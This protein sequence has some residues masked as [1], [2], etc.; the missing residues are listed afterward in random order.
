MIS[1]CRT[2]PL[3]LTLLCQGLLLV[4]TP[5]TAKE[6][7]YPDPQQ[8]AKQPTFENWK[9]SGKHGAVAA[10]GQRAVDA[11]IAMLKSDGNAID[12]AVATLLALTVTDSNSYCFGGE[13]PI[14]VYDAK[15]GVV[16]CLCGLGTA[17]KLA[18]REFFAKMGG[19]PTRGKLPAA[20]PGAV[21]A[22]LTALDRYGTKTFAECASSTLKILDEGAKDWHP[23][24]AKTIRRMIEAEKAS[25]NDRKRGLRLV[26]DYFYRGPIAREI[27]QWS[28]ANGGL[29]R[30]SD[31]ATHFTRIDD[32][33]HA[34]YRGHTVYKCN[35]W[36]Q[37]P[38]VLEALGILEG[39]DLAKMG[40]NSPDA[41]HTEIEALKLG[42]ADR[43]R[44]F[45]DPNYADVPL[46]DMLAPSYLELRRKLIDPKAASTALRPG[47]PRHGKALLDNPKFR[48]GAEDE[49]HDTTTCIVADDKGNVMA[50]TPSGFA[51]VQY[52]P[53]G[54]WM[55]TR[56]QSF[57]VWEGH[58]NCIEYGKR[59]RITLSPGLVFKDGNPLL[60]ISVAGGDQQEQ[61]ALQLMVNYID[62][63]LSPAEAVSAPRFATEHFI[64]SFAQAPPKLRSLYLNAG[65][66]QETIAE[67]KNRGHKLTLKTGDNG[68]QPV[69]IRI[70][71]KTGVMEAAGDPKARRHAGAW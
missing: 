68:A 4:V 20:V 25:P 60:V 35:V 64:S 39:F 50:A 61:A 32:P 13:I 26:A 69:M 36:T 59:P 22:M 43:D 23:Q 66:S 12:A 37:G 15:R 33:V 47:D 11:G 6:P 70:D 49:V 44:Y 14:M 27:D 55:G 34:D 52:G 30:Y 46:K 2:L 54:V 67:L 41:I 16:E 5:S 65:F 28:Q 21:D 1:P 17:P 7:A 24:L 63:G 18:T 51:G 40:H 62:F 9:A 45:A 48:F 10:G 31:L 19:I 56:L 3:V 38:Y 53:T 71:P 57:N 8:K 42:L 58:E 29:I